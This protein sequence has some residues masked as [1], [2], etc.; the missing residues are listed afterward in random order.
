[1]KNI[2]SILLAVMIALAVTANASAQCNVGNSSVSSS[3]SSTQAVQ[4]QA[5]QNF[6]NQQTAN[7]QLAQLNRGAASSAATPG[8]AAS[9]SAGGLN[10]A[11]APQAFVMQAPCAVPAPAGVT[12]EEIEAAVAA[13]QASKQAQY[14]AM[15]QMQA[16]PVFYAPQPTPVLYA[17][18]AMAGGGASASSA[19]GGASSS[20]SSSGGISAPVF[21][22]STP[23]L[24]VACGAGNC[25]G[26]IFPLFKGRSKSVSRSRSV[27][28]TR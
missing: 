27:S 21:L 20:A 14:F 10:T 4:N 2:C 22:T 25:R 8:S 16:A 11:V 9:S 19:A 5:I 23:V 7:A 6:I 12:A 15:A 24:Q 17:A 1:M 13:L 26:D 18:P 3:A 28:I